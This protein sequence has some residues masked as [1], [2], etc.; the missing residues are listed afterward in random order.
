MAYQWR[1]ESSEIFE[2]KIFDRVNSIVTYMGVAQGGKITSGPFWKI[3][4][5]VTQGGF[6]TIDVTH[7]R[8]Y[9]QIWDNRTSLFDPVLWQNHYST[10]FDGVNDRVD[11]TDVN[12]SSQLSTAYTVSAWVKFANV[13]SSNGTLMRF[14]STSD[15]RALFE[16][17][18][19]SA[20]SYRLRFFVQDNAGS[21]V[22]AASTLTPSVGV[23]YHVVGVRSGNNLVI[24]INGVSAGTA[25]GTIGTINTLNRL[26]LGVRRS[27]G[28]DSGFLPGN[29]DEVTIWKSAFTADQ[30][31]SLY[32]AGA[33]FSPFFHTENAQLVGYWT[34]GDGDTFPVLIDQVSSNAGVM[35][36]M[37]SDAF[38]LVVP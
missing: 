1:G 28:S 7:S 22:T 9:D 16:L 11:I 3:T 19:N 2:R 6:E 15:G 23:W 26:A 21:T 25:S 24:Y 4:R 31:A 17:S 10:F 38:Q 29:L 18:T 30:V 35:Q 8:N 32:N 12:I 13:G 34:M 33:P 27:G 20:D 14:G 36:N 37:A 5:F